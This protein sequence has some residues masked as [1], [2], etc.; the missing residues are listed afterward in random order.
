MDQR[1]ERIL[2]LIVDEY[3]RTAEPV[4][5][6]FLVEKHKLEASPATI[7][8]HMAALELEGYLASPHTSAGRVPTEKAFV[9]YLRHFVEPNRETVSD[10]RLREAVEASDEELAV[11]T[12][13]K[14]LVNLSGEM[15]IV[16]FGKNSGYY[17]GVANLFQKPEFSNLE[18]VQ[19]LSAMMDRFDDVVSELYDAVND[20]PQVLIGSENPFGEEMSAI[21]IKYQLPSRHVGILGLI[22]PMRMDYARNI[23]LVEAAKDILHEEDDV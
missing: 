9:Y 16:S 12:L 10:D 15:A 1:Q 21:V 17:T 23:G 7:R 3:I 8:N 13:A 20:E 2:K 22:G 6:K 5:S 14:T 18:V 4:G 11:K 19:S